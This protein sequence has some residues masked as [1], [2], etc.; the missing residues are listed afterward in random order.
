MADFD[1]DKFLAETSDGFDP[2]KFLAETSD[3]F[4]P[5]AYLSGE[6]PPEEEKSTLESVSGFVD[7]ITPRLPVISDIGQHAA[8]GLSALTGEAGELLGLSEEQDL[9]DRYREAMA[10]DQ[11][12][13]AQRIEES[14]ILSGAADFAG[15]AMVP[16]GLAV[17]A[18]V[19]GTDTLLKSGD[20]MEALQAAAIT[21]VGGKALES[22]GGAIA[23]GLSKLP[24]K[25]RSKGIKEA[26]NLIP[27]TK[28]ESVKEYKST[29]LTDQAEKLFDSGLLDTKK[30]KREIADAMIAKQ[31][32]LVGE[33]SDL[34]TSSEASKSKLDVYKELMK[35]MDGQTPESQAAIEASL[36]KELMDPIAKQY[37]KEMQK[38]KLK[39]D[40]LRHK[41]STGVQVDQKMIEDTANELSKTSKLFE[42][43]LSDTLNLDELRQMRVKYDNA[44]PASSG[45]DSYAPKKATADAFREMEDELSGGA[46]S[47]YKQT[48]T[49]W[50]ENAPIED[51]LIKSAV[52]TDRQQMFKPSMVD[53]VI[54]IPAGMAVAG[55]VGGVAGPPLVAAARNTWKNHGSQLKIIGYKK[56][57]KLFQDPKYSNMIKAWA[58]SGPKAMQAGHFIMMSRDPEYNKLY[59]E[60]KGLEDEQ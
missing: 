23:K 55:P 20:P 21:G 43:K 33:M 52:E 18:G 56:A 12:R 15:G 24:E 29:D 36:N 22:A 41:Q 38:L 49:E 7:S 42:D 57:G 9:A 28:G 17:Q 53:S 31:Q 45:A 26:E 50:S 16:G 60:D 4:D 46:S 2:D 27:R 32:G 6:T 19:A 25:F 37:Q 5:D 47:A 34:A 48:K 11:A 3:G 10:G 44:V 58:D 54:G 30:S 13:E 39:L 40:V 59:T 1:P 8:A 14:P 51:S 35:R